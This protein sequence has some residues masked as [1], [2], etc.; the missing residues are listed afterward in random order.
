MQTLISIVKSLSYM[1][2]RHVG[3][4]YPFKTQKDM[5]LHSCTGI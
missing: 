2:L 3:I 4:V 1:H 5:I